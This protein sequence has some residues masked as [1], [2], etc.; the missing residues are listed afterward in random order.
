[1]ACPPPPALNNKEKKM[2]SDRVMRNRLIL[3]TILLTAGMVAV[4]MVQGVW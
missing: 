1:M 3:S 4:F 2:V